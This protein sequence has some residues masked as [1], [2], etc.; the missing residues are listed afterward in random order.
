M[1]FVS[2]LSHFPLFIVPVPPVR[3]NGALKDSN[4]QWSIGED[5][6]DKGGNLR[7]DNVFQLPDEIPVKK[8]APAE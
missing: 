2:Q 3:M 6:V 4:G 1:R 8:R 7:T 5:Q